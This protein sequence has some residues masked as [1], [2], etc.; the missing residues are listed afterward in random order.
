MAV[1]SFS[2]SSPDVLNDLDPLSRALIDLSVKRGMS[3]AEIADIVGTDADA[4]FENRV[5]LLRSLAEQVAPDAVDAE[6]P[7]LE[8]A[9]ADRLYH[10]PDAPAVEDAPENESDLADAEGTAVEAFEDD[11]DITEIQSDEPVAAVEP[12]ATPA[13]ATPATAP[14][15]TERKRRSPLAILLPLLILAALAAAVVLIASGGDSD[16]SPQPPAGQERPS[17]PADDRPAGD[18]PQRVRLSA[19]GSGDASG[20]ASLDGSRLR[21]RVTGLPPA[22]DAAYEVW[23]YDS[24]IDARSIG[25]VGADGTLRAELPEGARDFRSLDVSREPADGNRNHS[26]QSVLRVPLEKLGR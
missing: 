9:V 19:L 20:T 12:A 2:H 4:V 5:A 3:D 17:A 15:D 10:A 21:L 25:R 7:E 18:A 26:G 22:E 6:V 13:A 14:A 11:R 1:D 16:D 23:L 24:V 8:A